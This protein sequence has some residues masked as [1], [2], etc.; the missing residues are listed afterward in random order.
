MLQHSQQE[1]HLFPFTLRPVI[2][3]LI[4]TPNP[5]TEQPAICAGD[6]GALPSPHDSPESSAKDRC[7]PNTLTSKPDG[8][9]G[10][11]PRRPS[12]RFTTTL[13]R[14]FRHCWHPA[15]VWSEKPAPLL[16]G[17]RGREPPRP[18]DVSVTA[19]HVHAPASAPQTHWVS[20]LSLTP[21]RQ[22]FATQPT[23]HIAA[24]QPR[25]CHGSVRA[26]CRQLRKSPDRSSATR[27]SGIRHR[28][29]LRPLSPF[30]LYLWSSGI[31]SRRYRA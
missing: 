26:R 7:D 4:T 18:T 30:P 1:T 12:E 27:G 19:S 11:L 9:P 28:T 6:R 8:R 14:L 21:E 10:H 23:T 2:R 3:P 25:Q 15:A 22:H 29:R 13:R 17:I 5:L 20:Y 24:T 31:E 16:P